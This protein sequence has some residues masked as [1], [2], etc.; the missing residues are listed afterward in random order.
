MTPR[1][2]HLAK[3]LFPECQASAEIT[4][5]VSQI[6]CVLGWT[7]HPPTHYSSSGYSFIFHF[8]F[9]APP[10]TQPLNLKFWVSSL[11]GSA[12]FL[13]LFHLCTASILSVLNYLGTPDFFLINWRQGA[14]GLT[15]SLFFPNLLA[16]FWK[17]KA[18][19][20]VGCFPVEII[21]KPG[22]CKQGS[23]WFGFHSPLQ[24][25]ILSF[26][27]LNKWFYISI[28]CICCCLGLEMAFSSI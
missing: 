23:L 12:S 17:N 4:P 11:V 16:N 8:W 15:I 27:K 1:S 2:L 21:K 20:W 5:H 7:P 6:Q 18:N 22:H 10:F 28:L 24:S 19:I 14:F 13:C 9:G 3:D 26:F 25:C